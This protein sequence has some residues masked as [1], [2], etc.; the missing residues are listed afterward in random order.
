[1]L[2]GGTKQRKEAPKAGSFTLNYLTDTASL[3][4]MKVTSEQHDDDDEFGSF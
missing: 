3:E 2:R 4:K 1:M